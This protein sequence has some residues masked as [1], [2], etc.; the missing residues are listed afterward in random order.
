MRRKGWKPA[1]VH[2]MFALGGL[3]G[4]AVSYDYVRCL[5]AEHNPLEQYLDLDLDAA[6]E[7]F[8]AA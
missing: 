5:D 2:A 6:L 1:L 8:F 4:V 3:S 7:R